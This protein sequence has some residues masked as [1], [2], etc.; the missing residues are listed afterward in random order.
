MPLPPNSTT[1][2]RMCHV[3][4]STVAW[5]RATKPRFRPGVS[6]PASG[7]LQVITGEQPMS[8]RNRTP[9]PS[10]NG[11]E[12]PKPRRIFTLVKITGEETD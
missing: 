10:S 2:L 11:E 1:A 3:T 12:K 9:D 8:E 7:E 6:I 5:N 4:S